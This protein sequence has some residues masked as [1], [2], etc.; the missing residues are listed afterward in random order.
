MTPRGGAW[1]SAGLT[2]SLFG[3]V[4]LLAPLDAPRSWTPDPATFA[5]ITSLLTRLADAQGCPVWRPG[6]VRTAAEAGVLGGRPAVPEPDAPTLLLRDGA[7]RALFALLWPGLGAD[8][9]PGVAAGMP[10]W[11]TAVLGCIAREPA[12]T[13]GELADTAAVSPE[14]MRRAFHRHLG[15]APSDYLLRA[16]LDAARRLLESGDATV[17]AVSR[18]VGF[19]SLSYFTRRYKRT[20]GHTPAQ[21]RRPGA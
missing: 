10:E 1:L 15:V 11:L 2:A 12:V 5:L 17:A 8:S 20:F 19:E 13:L 7:A 14:Q 21:H 18:Q 6:G 3:G 4:D 16:R 9:A